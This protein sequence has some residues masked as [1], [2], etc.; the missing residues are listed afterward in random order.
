MVK[1]INVTLNG[2]PAFPNHNAPNDLFSDID[3]DI[4]PPVLRNKCL[5]SCFWQLSVLKVNISWLIEATAFM[6]LF[7]GS[8]IRLFPSRKTASQ[9][10]LY[11]EA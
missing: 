1:G 11:K 3:I 7:F 5:P 10:Y 9:L 8:Q 2:V 6:Q 4:S